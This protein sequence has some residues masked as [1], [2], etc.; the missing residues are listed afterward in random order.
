MEY[1]FKFSGTSQETTKVSRDVPHTLDLAYLQFGEM[2][3]LLYYSAQRCVMNKNSAMKEFWFC[4]KSSQSTHMALI[5]SSKTTLLV[6]AKHS[7]RKY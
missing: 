2:Y 3:N 5:E 6:L 4:T 1:L 7:L